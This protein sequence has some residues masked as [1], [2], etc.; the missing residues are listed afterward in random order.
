[1]SVILHGEALRLSVFPKIFVR[2][3]GLSVDQ[4]CDLL[5]RLEPLALA[6]E[7]TRLS[8]RT[9][10]RAVGA[11]TPYKLPLC[12][13][14]LMLLMYHRTYVT[15]AFL[16]YLFKLDD[17]NVGR[18][19]NRLKLSLAKL[20]AIPERRLLQQDDVYTLFLM[21]LS[22]PSSARK[23]SKPARLVT[24]VKRNGTR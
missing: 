4:F 17:S 7:R 18:C 15:H 5:E 21:P 11:G 3:T 1:M 14:L 6:S 13:R 23:T 12:D 20:F 10:E 22:N 9:R 19:I 8:R 24:Q 2:L 16:G